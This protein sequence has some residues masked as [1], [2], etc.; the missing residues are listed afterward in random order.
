MNILAQSEMELQIS[1]S[2]VRHYADLLRYTV[3][4]NISKNKKPHFHLHYI[5][6]RLHFIDPSDRL[7]ALDMKRV[8]YHIIFRC[9]SYKQKRALDTSSNTSL[10]PNQKMRWVYKKP[11]TFLNHQRENSHAYSRTKGH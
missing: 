10:I 6:L 8:I 11:D 3:S 5:T 7:M 2:Y 1:S 4:H 9:S